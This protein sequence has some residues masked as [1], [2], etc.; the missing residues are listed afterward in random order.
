MNFFLHSLKTC[1][2]E[3]NLT[4]YFFKVIHPVYFNHSFHTRV[5]ETDRD[6]QQTEYRYY[7]Y[8]QNGLWKENEEWGIRKEHM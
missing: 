5:G 8:K 4:L 1:P 3:K 6:D 7:G 2:L